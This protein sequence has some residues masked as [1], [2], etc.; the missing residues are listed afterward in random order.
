MYRQINHS[1]PVDSMLDA[2]FLTCSRITVSRMLCNSWHPLSAACR[3]SQ[4]RSWWSRP[5]D[6]KW[7]ICL[8]LGRQVSITILH[9]CS[10]LLT[11]MMVVDPSPEAKPKSA[12]VHEHTMSFM[13]TP[14]STSA[15]V[16]ALTQ[17]LNALPSAWRTFTLTQTQLRKQILSFQY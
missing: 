14:A 4:S 8:D 15:S 11:S 6:S 16:A 13:A 2:S 5:E 10:N 12:A 9:W 7:T 3:R 17:T 1:Q